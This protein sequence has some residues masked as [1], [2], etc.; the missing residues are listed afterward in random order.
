[1]YKDEKLL[2]LTADPDLEFK[3][4]IRTMDEFDI[5][6]KESSSQDNCRLKQS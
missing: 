2:T 5:V 1:M 4:L 3:H 6:L